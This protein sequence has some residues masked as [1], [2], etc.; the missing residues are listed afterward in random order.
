MTPVLLYDG[1]CTLCQRSVRFILR[2]EKEPK[3]HFASLQSETG[4]SLQQ[5][6]SL[7]D[8]LDAVVL[9]DPDGAFTGSDAALRVC[10]YLRL[11]WRLFAVLRHLPSAPFQFLYR[12]VAK[13]RNRWFGR[14]QDCPI[15]APEVSERF[16]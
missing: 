4:R 7:P 14:S 8:D 11:P 10:L 2:W 5:Q 6:H 12:A 13:R 15:P 9:I 1:P 3:L 16:L